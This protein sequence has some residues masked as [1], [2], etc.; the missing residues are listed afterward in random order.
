MPYKT[1]EEVRTARN[2]AL[3]NTDFW[4]ALDT[5]Y[6]IQTMHIHYRQDLRDATEGVY[7]VDGSYVKNSDGNLQSSD[8]VVFELPLEPPVNPRNGKIGSVG[9]MFGIM[10]Q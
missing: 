7:S 10:Y 2:T 5:P 4:F 3:A 8:G 1:I 6:D 9:E